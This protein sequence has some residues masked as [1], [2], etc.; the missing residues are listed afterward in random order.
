MKRK[1]TLS[2]FFMAIMCI[3]AIAQQASPIDMIY[4]PRDNTFAISGVGGSNGYNQSKQASS[5]GQIALDWNI[6]L[7]DGYSKRN[8]N[9]KYT[10]LTT[11]FKY[12][13]L[14][15]TKYMT[16]DSVEMKKIGFVDNEFIMMLGMRISSVT[17]MGYDA[18]AKFMKT[19]FVDA[20]MSPFQVTSVLDTTTS[21]FKSFNIN[22][23]FQLGYLANTSFG[24]VGFGIA[25]EASFI[26]IYEDEANG[27]AFEEFSNSPYDFSHSIFGYGLKITVPLNDFCFFFEFRNYMPVSNDVVIRGLTDRTIFSFGGVAT[28]TVFKSNSDDSGYNY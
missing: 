8:S 4:A 11:V 9:S 28:G 10:T 5:S 15:Q 3:S 23:G 26:S 7:K 16:S 12:N 22:G 19:F 21:G 14:F 27:R 20:T 6:A 1:I 2:V 18:E 17:D 24:I 25:P 13:P